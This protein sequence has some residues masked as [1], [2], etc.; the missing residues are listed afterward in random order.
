MFVADLWRGYDERTFDAAVNHAGTQIIRRKDRAFGIWQLHRDQSPAD[1]EPVW[2]AIDVGPVSKDPDQPPETNLI[3]SPD[4]KCVAIRF[5]RDAVAHSEDGR[6]VN[7]YLYQESARPVLLEVTNSRKIGRHMKIGQPHFS[8]DS[9]QLIVPCEHEKTMDLSLTLYDIATR[10][11]FSSI[12]ADRKVVSQPVFEPNSAIYAVFQWGYSV[13][14]HDMDKGADGKNF[15]PIHAHAW[16]ERGGQISFSPDG[17]QLAMHYPSLVE[18]SGFIQVQSSAVRPSVQ[19]ASDGNDQNDANI[20][21]VSEFGSQVILGCGSVIMLGAEHEGMYVFSTREDSFGDELTTEHNHTRFEGEAVASPDGVFLAAVTSTLQYNI[22]TYALCIFHMSTGRKLHTYSA[23]NWSW[24]LDDE[25]QMRFKIK[26]V[27]FCQRLIVSVGHV[28]F[29]GRCEL[30]REALLSHDPAVINPA[31]HKAQRQSV[32]G[33]K[34]H[35][36]SF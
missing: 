15:L 16:H 23:D 3:W 2:G 17:G 13:I 24:Q 34:L 4:D 12:E 22:R 29:E 19:H 11:R 6:L 30:S 36:F 25:V 21:E 9:R 31:F 14:L 26:W 28:I 20:L 7:I 33:V 1:M 8:Q 5:R 35:V 27:N 32:V 10:Q 18:P